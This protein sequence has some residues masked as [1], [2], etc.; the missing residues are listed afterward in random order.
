MY[1]YCKLKGKIIEV[2]GSQYL[3]AKKMGWSERTCSLKLN[4][5]IFW[6]QNEIT[7]ACVLLNICDADLQGYFFKLNVQ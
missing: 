4:G 6:K 5:K 1:D 7:K 3:F 2:F